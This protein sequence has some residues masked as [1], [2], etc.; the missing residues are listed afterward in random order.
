MRSALRRLPHTT[1][2]L[3][4]ASVLDRPAKPRT[5]RYWLHTRLGQQ[6]SWRD[7]CADPCCCSEHSSTLFHLCAPTFARKQNPPSRGA[8]PAQVFVKPPSPWHNHKT[9]AKDHGSSRS[10]AT[11]SHMRTSSA[12]RMS[13]RMRL[14]RAKPSTAVIAL[15]TRMGCNAREQ[16]AATFVMHR[17]AHP[18]RRT[19]AA[20]LNKWSQAWSRLC[21][22]RESSMQKC[23]HS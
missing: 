6:Y 2:R 9:N 18:R 8:L 19:T 14:Y 21:P 20:I 15:I 16:R 4:F 22:G 11:G 12:Y 5:H 1:Q 10:P 7:T 17:I 23:V 3:A 13:G